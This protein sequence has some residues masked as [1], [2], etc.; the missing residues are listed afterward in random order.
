MRLIR[1][2]SG[3]AA[4]E[5]VVFQVTYARNN[6]TKAQ[7]TG[8]QFIKKFTLFTQRWYD[9]VCHGPGKS[10]VFRTRRVFDIRPT[11]RPQIV[12]VA[13]TIK[14][15]LPRQSI[16]ERPELELDLMNSPGNYHEFIN[17]KYGEESIDPFTYRFHWLENATV[18]KLQPYLNLTNQYPEYFARVEKATLVT[19]GKREVTCPGIMGARNEKIFHLYLKCDPRI[20]IGENLKKYIYTRVKRILELLTEND[21]VIDVKNLQLRLQF[22][23]KSECD[24]QLKLGESLTEE[25]KKIY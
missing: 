13:D 5:M 24:W 17:P 3:N 9:W 4:H 25:I 6:P 10:W 23:R 19:K 22:W 14:K 2:N 18:E 7:L 15:E 12:N 11:L 16:K 8:Q 21:Y 20:Q 1:S